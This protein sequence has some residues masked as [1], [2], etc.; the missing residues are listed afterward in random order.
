MT[1]VNST[2]FRIFF[3]YSIFSFITILFISS[4]ILKQRM[5]SIENYHFLNG[6]NC[7]IINIKLSSKNMKT[8]SRN[9]VDLGVNPRPI[10]ILLKEEPSRSLAQHTLWHIRSKVLTIPLTSYATTPFA[11]RD[12]HPRVNSQIRENTHSL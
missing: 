4:L 2:I 9:Q 5:L 10:D 6:M 8:G 1:S 3:I 7:V 12:S 11:F